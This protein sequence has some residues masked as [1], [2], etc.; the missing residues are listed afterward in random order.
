MDKTVKPVL[1]E[2]KGDAAFAGPLDEA[3]GKVARNVLHLV[4]G[5]VATTV[6]AI[7]LNSQL[8]RWLGAGDFGLYYFLLTSMSFANVFIEWGQGIVLIRDV[9]RQPDR[10]PSLLGSAA[11]IRIGIALPAAFASA[12]VFWL[13]DYELRTVG[14]M[15][16]IVIAWIPTAM[17]QLVGL[18]FRGHERMDIDAQATV[19]SKV[20]HVATVVTALNLG[21]RL[22]AVVFSLGASGAAALAWSVRR[23]RVIERR[24]PRVE[25]STMR[26][27]IADGGPLLFLGVLG[28]AQVYVET[29]IVSSMAPQEV[30]GWYGAAKSIMTTL[31]MPA[32]IL[33]TALLP[34]LSRNLDDP[35]ALRRELSGP[36]RI[37]LILGVCATGG[38]SLFAGV[39]TGLIYG[40]DSFAPSS[41]LLALMAPGLLLLYVNI[42]IA[43]VVVLKGRTTAVSILRV[44]VIGVMAVLAV[45]WIPLAQ[46]RWNN[47]AIGAVAVSTLGEVLLLVGFIWLMPHNA[48]A[49][50]VW[51]DLFR[52]AICA[53]VGAGAVLL[54]PPSPFLGIPL[55]LIVFGAV[56]LATRL[57]RPSDMEMLRAVFRRR[58]PQSD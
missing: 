21:G 5:Q 45:W 16:L 26:Q 44:V 58:V 1:A 49:K 18:V 40:S 43:S 30:L 31:I 8:G 9:A 7:L 56:A 2:P 36:L 54:V 46:E 41:T 37:I 32:P 51:L 15:A 23:L 42:L 17:L 39:A 13:L 34:T 12:L 55:F 29:L 57:V 48:F 52:A 53:A 24:L 10:T 22:L 19:L 47:G 27:L 38:T 50:S 6:L 28:Q 4:S 35:I 3:R 20:V 25:I 33:V 11:A 14:L